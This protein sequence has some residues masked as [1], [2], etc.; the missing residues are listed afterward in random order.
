M[1][2]KLA[3]FIAAFALSAPAL[4]QDDDDASTPGPKVCPNLQAS[5]VFVKDKRGNR[6][7]GSAD[8]L[9]ETHRTAQEQGWDFHDLEIYIEDG[10]LPGFFV[11]YTREH[12]CNRE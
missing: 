6:K 7:D 8:R 10:D 11:T 1:K 12:P 5:T 9:S 2:T 4:A 3:A